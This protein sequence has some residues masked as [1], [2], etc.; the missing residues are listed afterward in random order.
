MND[1]AQL[2]C[3]P[4]RKGDAPLSEAE[5]SDLLVSLPDWEIKERESRKRL[6][7]SFQFPDFKEALEFA[8]RV[9]ELAEEEDHHPA[10]LISWGRAAVSWWTFVIDGLHQNDFILAARTDLLYQSITQQGT[11]RKER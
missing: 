8:N 1:L 3:R 4:C 2:T 11:S 7:R 9:G 10:I 5:I 6:E